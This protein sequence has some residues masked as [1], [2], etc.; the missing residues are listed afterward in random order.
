MSEGAAVDDAVRFA[1]LFAALPSPHVAVDP[2][3]HVVD[4]SDSYLALFGMRRADVVGRPIVALFPPEPGSVDADG[5]PFILQSFLRAARDRRPDPMPV[6]R[7]DITDASGALVERYWSHVAFPVLDQDGAEVLLV[8]QALTEVT[9]YV[10]REQASG[11]EPAVEGVD[12]WRSRAEA[13]EAQLLARVGEVSEARAAER[14]ALAMRAALAETAVG[15]AGA[16]TVA[17]LDQVLVD[18]GRAAVG[19]AVGAVGVPDGELL[20]QTISADAGAPIARY[21]TLPLHGALHPAVVSREGAPVLLP[22]PA[23]CA[24]FSDEMAAVVAET[25]LQA[26]V[27]FPVRVGG[28]LRGAISFGWDHPRRFDA[29]DADVLQALAAQYGQGVERIEARRAERS[30]MAQAVQMSEAMQRS[31]LAE[32]LAVPGLAVTARYRPAAHLAQIGG[33]WFDSFTTPDGL[34]HL[35]VG[36]VS[37]HDQDAAALMGQARNVL[38]GIA[39]TTGAAPADVVRRLDLA[40]RDLRSKVYA[41]LVLATVQ[42]DPD[43]RTTVEWTN[44]GHPVPLVVRSDGRVEVLATRPEPMLGV[45]ADRVRAGHTAVLEVG[46][47]LLLHTD[48]LVERRR[49]D[50]DDGL[51]WL[52]D[53]VTAHVGSGGRR[54]DLCDHLLALVQGHTEDDVVVLT[55]TVEP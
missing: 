36:D 20:R 22:D 33:D 32:P 31:L 27:G 43:G 35:V 5:V 14:D 12:G 44:A 47:M 21:T 3:M 48:G 34:V 23:A 38:R 53:A 52:A 26:F 7:Y 51:Q 6:A 50:L 13:I 42:R 17:E 55:L 49:A 9:E 10:L 30:R 46:D 29:A 16:E 11:H 8:V 39:Q 37:G 24:A 4:A 28:R 19:A 54:D 41:T 1:R 2:D 18:L 15:M 40:L 45:D 25:G